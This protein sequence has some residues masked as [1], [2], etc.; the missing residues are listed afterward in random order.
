[1][2]IL[3]SGANGF[4]GRNLMPK[5]RNSDNEIYQIT[6]N[7]EVSRKIYGNKFKLFHYKAHNQDELRTEVENFQPDIYI[8]L[9]AF[10]TANDDHETLVKLLDANILFTCKML[11]SL[12]NSKIKAFINTGT[13]AEYY[14]GDGEIDPAYLYA[15]TKSASRIFVDYYSKTYDFKDITI[16]PYT[17]YGGNDSKKKI[18]DIIYDSLDNTNSTDLTPGNQ[19]LDFIHI[20]DVIDFYIEVINKISLIPSGT[21]FELGTGLGH[22]IKDLVL[23]FEKYTNKKSNIN[24]GG[25]DYR[26]RD[27]MKAIANTDNAISIVDW[28]PKISLEDG[29]K[30]YL[31]IKNEAKE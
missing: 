26:P 18:I 7:P 16:T 5:L 4:V 22:T 12:K 20:E 17:I 28:E 11:D 24:W 2:R 14:K 30:K 13:F 29:V 3:I 19:I 10:L 15:A 27:V 6:T 9:A 25:K 21:N 8:H 1:M 31:E 23:L